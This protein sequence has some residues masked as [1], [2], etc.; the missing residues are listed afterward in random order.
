MEKSSASNPQSRFFV[1]DHAL[2]SNE[3]FK[4][5][6]ALNIENLADVHQKLGEF[7]MGKRK[8]CKHRTRTMIWK[9]DSTLQEPLE[10][11]L[12]LLCHHPPPPFV[13]RLSKQKF[14]LQKIFSKCLPK[15]SSLRIYF[16]EYFWSRLWA[17]GRIAERLG[18]ALEQFNKTGNLKDY[19]SCPV[20][21]S[22]LLMHLMFAITLRSNK[23]L[24]FKLPRFVFQAAF[25]SECAELFPVAFYKLWSSRNSSWNCE[26]NFMPGHILRTLMM[27]VASF[28]SFHFWKLFSFFVV[29]LVEKGFPAV[30]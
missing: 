12:K 3:H 11:L 8:I 23:F 1:R 14:A 21:N 13:S 26:H 20:R 27:N 22:L 25:T 29:M 16:R 5:H 18:N 19:Q 15:M 6:P 7:H 30:P 4:H 2:Y 10:C 24:E 9:F 17:G 28:F